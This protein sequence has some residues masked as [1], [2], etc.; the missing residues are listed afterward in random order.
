MLALVL[1]AGC[2][3]TPPT[4][5]SLD[6]ASHAALYQGWWQAVSFADPVSPGASS[7]PQPTVPASDNTAYVVLAPGWDPSSQTAPTSFVVLRSRAGYSVHLG[8]TLHITVDDASFEGD[9]AAGS[10]LTQAEAD[11][12]TSLVFPSV[13]AGYAYDAATCTTTPTGDAAP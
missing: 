9:C 1:A 11:T 3:G 5:V 12:I 13:F 4:Y 10:H 8:D 6:N 2:N 7:G